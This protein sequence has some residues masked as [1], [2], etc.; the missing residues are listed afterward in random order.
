VTIAEVVQQSTPLETAARELSKRHEISR[1]PP[2]PIPVWAQIGLMPKWLD[3]ARSAATEPTPDATKAAEW[4]LDNDYQVRRAILQIEEDLPAN[5]YRRLLSLGN[6]DEAGM[7][8]VFALAHGLLR[9]SRLQLSSDVVECFVR[10]YQEKM[11]LTIAELWALP[12]MLRLACLEILVGAF[13]RLVPEVQPPFQKTGQARLP[14]FFDD[15]ECASRAIANLVIIAGI[16]WKNFFDRTS[17]VEAILKSEEAGFY[18]RMDFDTRD[19]Y[20][21]AIEELARGSGRPETDVAETVL[22]QSRAACPDNPHDHIGF[23]L[24]GGGRNLFEN[25]LGYRPSRAVAVKR[26]LL[27]YPEL[28][29]ATALA[30]AALAA[31]VLPAVYLAAGATPLIWIVGIAL[32]LMPASVIGITIVHWIVTLIV[33]PRVLPKLDFEKAIAPDCS[34]AVAVPVLVSGPEEVSKLIERLER[35]YLANR[36]P[37]VR[38]VLLSDLLDAPAERMPSDDKAEQALVDGIRRLNSR[39]G[40]KG[41]G[42]F[43][44]LHRRRQYNTAQCC[45]M[46]WER[47]RGKLECFNRF[48]LGEAEHAFSLC[49]GTTEALRGTRFVVTVDA[50]TLL[51][52][53][54]VARLVGTLAHPLNTARFDAKSGRVTAGYTVIQPRV[55][56]APESGNESLFTRLYA[57]DTAIDIYSRAVSDVYQDLFGTGIF[58]GKGIYE[59]DPLHRSLKGRVPENALLS[60]DLLEGAYG[61]AA[62]ASDI[63]LYEGFPAS[64][65]EYTRRWH[66]WV[67]GDWQLLPWLAKRGPS[68]HR[69]HPT[70]QLS[71]LD[72]W[73]IFDNLRRSLIP[74]SLVAL[75]VAGWLVLPGNAWVWTLLAI[76]APAAYLFTDLV[77][78][79][80]RGR[81]RGAVRGALR[82]A[83][84]H[85]GRWFLAVVFLFQDAIVALDAIIRT[86]W[87]LFVSRRNLLEW[88]PAAHTAARFAVGGPR[89]IAWR[90]M[91]TAP[92]FSVLLGGTVAAVNPA[93]FAP[94]AVILLLWLVSPEVAVAI[95]RPRHPRAIRLDAEDRA[96]LRRVARRTWLYFETFVGPEDNWLPPDNFQ[97][98][99]YK[100]TAHRTSPT[101]IGMM[102]LSCLTAWDLGYIGSNELATRSRNALNALDRLQRHRGHVLNWYDTRTLKPLEP[103]YVSTV[104]SGNLAVCLQALK[105]GCLET[106]HAPAIHG[107]HWDGLTDELALF[108]QAVETT[109]SARMRSL[110]KCAATIVEKIRQIR[111]PHHDWQSVL[112]D[113]IDGDFAKLESSIR[114]TR[115]LLG[116]DPSEALRETHVWLERIRHHV[117]SMRRDF[118]SFRP[119]DA[120]LRTPAPDCEDIARSISKTLPISLSL[121]EAGPACSEARRMLADDIPPEV[122]T[123]NAQWICDVDAALIRGAKSQSELRNSFRDIAARCETAALAMDFRFLFDTEAR[124]FHIG[125]NVSSD[126]I[127]LHHYDLLASEARLAS[128][129]AIAKG[130]VPV[131]HWFFLGRP[132]AQTSAG[133]LLVSWNGSMFEYLMPPL[134]MHSD[135]GT[136]LGQSAHAVVKFQRRYANGL[137]IPWGMS[138][139]AFAS[140]DH[141]HRYRY[142]AF[143]V[144][145]LGLRRGL[146]LDSVVAPYATALA[147]SVSPRHAVQ[148]LRELERLG[149]SGAYG[150]LEALDFTPERVETGQRFTPVRAYMAHHQGMIL[151]AIDNVLCDNILV[152]RF[153][154]DPRL[155]AIELLLHERVPWELPP[156]IDRP[157]ERRIQIVTQ[158]AVPSPHAWIPRT[159]DSFP[160]VHALGNGRLATWI[161][162]AGAGGLWY[163]GQALTRWQADTTRDHYGLWIYV[164][165]NDSGALWS[166]GRQPTSIEATETCAV[167]HPHMAEFHR[168]DEG[169]GITME[170]GIAAGDDVEI[171]RITVVNHNDRRRSLRLTSAAEVVL[172]APLQDER[173]PAF[174]KLFVGSEYF[175]E[176]N[177]LLFTRRPRSPGETPPVLFHRIITDDPALRITGYDSDR[178]S[179][180]G[181]NGT[182][183]RPRGVVEG[184][185]GKTGWT[186][187]PVMSLQLQI[188]LEPHA[189]R[190]FAF[191]TMAAGSRESVLELAERYA[192]LASLD[193]AFDEAEMDSAREAQNLGL[194]PDQLAELQ[195][196]TS[197][198]LYPNRMLGAPA[199]VIDANHLGQSGLWSLG[200]S[201]DS[202]ILVVGVNEVKETDLL[203][204]LIRGHQ[205]WRRRGIAVDLVFVRTGGSGYVE[206]IRDQLFN[207]LRE[208]GTHEIFGRNGGIHLIFSDQVGEE[209]CRLI[210]T[211]ARVVLHEDKGTLGQQLAA[212]MRRRSEVPVFEPT[213]DGE[214]AESASTLVRPADLLFDNGL[215][216]FTRDGREYVVHLEPG[217]TT[218]APWSNVLANAGFGSIVTEAGLGFTW[219]ANSGENRLTP[220]SNDPVADPPSEALYLRDE[221]TARI[222]TPTPRPA[223]DGSA[224]QIRHGAGYTKWQQHSH[225]LEQELLV[226][227]PP[228]DPVKIMQLR[229]RNRLSRPRRI[230]ATYYA[231]WLLGALRS[232]AKPFVVCGYDAGIQSLLAR[233]P[234]NP[235]FSERV[236]FLTSNRPP[237]SVTVDRMD[238]LGREAGFISPRG[239]RCWDLG[240]K[241]SPRTDPCAAFQV[242]LDIAAGETAEAVF[243]LGQGDSHTHTAELARRWKQPDQVEAGLVR[244]NRYWDDR[245][246]AVRVHTP[247]PAF[248]VMVNRWLLYGTLASRAL[249][250]AGFY[251]AGGAFGFR[252]QLQDVLAL[253]HADPGFARAHILESAARQFE[254]GDVLHWWHPPSNR[255]VRTRCSDDLLWLPYV[256][257]RY[258]DATGD[259]SIL[260]EEVPFLRAPT[261][262]EEEIDRYARFDHATERFTLFEHCHRAL[263]RGVTEGAHGLPLIGSGD[264]NDGMDRIGR[265]KRG[266]SV[267]LAW[268]AIAA[269]KGF[270]KLCAREQRNGLM[271][272]W[273]SRMRQLEQAV[274]NAG[275]DGQWYRRAFDDDERPWGSA[276]NDECRI[277]LIAQS[278][279]VLSGVAAPERTWAAIDAATEELVRKDEKVVRLLWPPFDKTP[280]DPGYIKAYP[281][282]IRENGGQYSHAA[283]WLGFAYADL[284]NGDAAAQI[285]EMINPISRSSTPSDMALYRVEPYVVAADIASVPPHVGRGGWTWY[286]GAAAWT[287]RLGVEAILGLRLREGLLAIDP[288]LPNG[289]GVFEAEIRGPQGSISIRVEDPEQIGRGVVEIVVDGLPYEEP[290][291]KFPTDGSVLHVH[292]CLHKR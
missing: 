163:H 215:G 265:G 114:E 108:S 79:L 234:W 200:L 216:G 73:K 99:P 26:L 267:W 30:A 184:L 217:A 197:L 68:A 87:R 174:M 25:V 142:R 279:A 102:M 59:V 161:T 221:E 92:L 119:W 214:S 124:L 132:M 145:E 182:A 23:W 20:R 256:V 45:W 291:L 130:D 257:S 35:H 192:T 88:T 159:A 137:D 241:V 24:I 253:F 47:K 205:Y 107:V 225:G 193:W 39:Y 22:V 141:E 247:D 259:T 288:C 280:R 58:I 183:R 213:I 209:S 144:P 9:A 123:E 129:F 252:D 12:T 41:V 178:E 157:P 122:H 208:M 94:A 180:L 173:H 158:K 85:L 243:V 264:W 285:F 100:E 261:L 198:I 55:E 249:A 273:T 206:P 171:R 40:S 32:V 81:R 248:D 118:E 292:V 282:G 2:Q 43:H 219:A 177:G 274:E 230:T 61:R 260:W 278:W 175:P 63:V 120:L 172:A 222:W 281:P 11:P 69:E 104:D 277:D 125:Y 232:N 66:R 154:T 65:I 166:V 286:T 128:F 196:L 255:G 176:S 246:G 70:Q 153:H 211:A 191:L 19:R 56:I 194:A 190:Q 239:L 74:I 113:L 44:L 101:N 82:R 231:D 185:S 15:T 138:E 8:R 156:Q 210:E 80:A 254:E 189:S 98:E 72:R 126:H 77:S 204:L 90:H 4:L 75:V 160:Q 235:D 258:V 71:L 188:D 96:F 245:L 67:R 111:S 31:L 244:L 290:L 207:L 54:C 155:R 60:H 170:V 266:E 103:R 18:P 95:N 121:E 84:D 117:T 48:I 3:R 187:D 131:E 149:G 97:E 5:F 240:G 262:S 21:K 64:Y 151:A 34:T 203:R 52:Q 1:A 93:A 147:L 162:E 14:E 28:L 17:Q 237:H 29:F 268:F 13:S 16:S 242:H 168:R 152:R 7:P 164:T 62:L 272:R 36:D 133:I 83:L 226:F 250:R 139:S 238:F 179:F 37:S 105:E 289:W 212:A 167:F 86:L 251:Q 115:T 76:A 6:T 233:N 135:P 150:L 134:L 269:M 263:E 53:G 109:S 91:W 127:D 50:D 146:A 51:P 78:G 116:N 46:G 110:G 148:N 271:E 220:C 218:P 27:R 199:E 202:P 89:A 229:L 195:L 57:G 106:L 143:G 186:L 112:I 169:I 283:A 10:A 270:A 201:G 284:G 49:E 181:R 275:W 287:W 236:A 224:C 33:P 223:G 228:D 165:D 227:V 38:F 42:P 140:R 136:L 276:T